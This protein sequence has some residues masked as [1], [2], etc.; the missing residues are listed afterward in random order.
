MTKKNLLL[1][2]DLVGPSNVKKLSRRA[3]VYLASK[4]DPA[5][6]T[7]LLP[8]ID[9]L[10]IFSWP[11]FLTEDSMARMPRL[12]FVQSILA[13][14]NHIP[15]KMLDR[16]VVVASNAGA[17]SRPVAEY[18]WALLLSAAKRVV[19]HHTSLREGRAVLVRHGDAAEGV[20]MLEHKTLG[21]LGYGG[22][23]EAVAQMSRPFR[24]RVLAF[25][26]TGMETA[27]VTALRG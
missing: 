20:Y 27:G 13:G 2:T 17:Y 21:I 14:V 10:M 24:M 25:T 16:T 26:R 8:L 6:L 15:F 7:A 9:A 1:T 22:I 19:E 23:G 4:L 5:N 3:N 18:A 12:R 11:K